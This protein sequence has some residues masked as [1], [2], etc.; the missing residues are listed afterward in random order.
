MGG[1][2]R[3]LRWPMDGRLEV[4]L[5]SRA[6]T[7]SICFSP[8]G[9]GPRQPPRRKPSQ[10]RRPSAREEQSKREIRLQRPDLGHC[11]APDSSDGHAIL[12]SQDLRWCLRSSPL[13]FSLPSLR[14]RGS[15]VG[16]RWRGGR[17]RAASDSAIPP[18]L[19]PPPSP[20]S[21]GSA[22]VLDFGR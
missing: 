2:L 11:G 21:L 19:C 14:Q 12:C 18:S 15:A 3:L 6:S 7:T 1:L 8:E 4:P 9:G 10:A 22:M 13:L 17:W 5:A 16:K 20:L